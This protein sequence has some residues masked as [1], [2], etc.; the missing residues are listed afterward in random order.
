MNALY[1]TSK[2]VI[3]IQGP[4]SQPVVIGQD[5]SLAEAI[6]WYNLGYTIFRWA[7]K[8]GR[9]DLEETLGE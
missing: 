8:H 5:E 1:D 7:F 2:N 6:F 3:A 9:F 4:G